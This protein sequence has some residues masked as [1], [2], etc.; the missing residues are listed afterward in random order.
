MKISIITCT[1]NSEKYLL[2]CLRSI[3]KQSHKDIEHIIIDA[4]STDKTINIINKYIKRNSKIKIKFFQFPP[5]GISNAMNFGIKH[6][7]GDII[8]FL[9]SDDFYYSPDSLQKVNKY[10]QNNL[11]CNWLVGNHLLSIYKITIIFPD[12]F[13]FKIYTKAFLHFFPWMSHQN[14]FMKKNIYQ[15]YGL[16]DETYKVHLDYEQWLRIIDHEQV[17]CLNDN[18]SVFRIHAGS[19]TFNPR[20][21]LIG[22]QECLRAKK[23]YPIL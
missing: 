4:F 10:F 1:Y 16:F 13:L 20:N 19:T 23:K 14:T 2:E 8:H 9:H 11:K 21:Y 22:F 7:T 6:S 17:L 3:E 5:R 15:K 12:P 18:F